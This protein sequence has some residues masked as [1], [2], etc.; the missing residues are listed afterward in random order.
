MLLTLACG[1]DE[2]VHLWILTHAGRELGTQVNESLLRV[3]RMCSC[4]PRP[5][6]C[7]HQPAW[8]SPARPCPH[9]AGPDPEVLLLHI[10]DVLIDP[11]V[12]QHLGGWAERSE[13]REGVQSSDST[14]IRAHRVHC[15]MLREAHRR[16]AIDAHG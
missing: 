12:T 9:R 6:Q 3:N 8:P 7:P 10:L 14:G 2:T 13:D 16:D 1:A 11:A 5:A 4:S 15:F